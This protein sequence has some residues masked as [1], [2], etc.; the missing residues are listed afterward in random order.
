MNCSVVFCISHGNSPS[1]DRV[2]R[3]CPQLLLRDS[4][5]AG[6]IVSRTICPAAGRA[7]TL[8]TFP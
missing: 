5:P 8:K 1:A 4:A 3:S 2:V 6:Y 7:I